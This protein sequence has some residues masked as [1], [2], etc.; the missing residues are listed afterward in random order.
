MSEPTEAASETPKKASLEW[1][2]LSL[3]G[4]Q[5]EGLSLSG[6]RTSIGLPQLNACFDVAQALPFA[7]KYKHFFISHGHQDHA[8]GLPY[9]I[10]QKNMNSHEPAQI[11]LP[12]ELAGPM[13]EI[14]SLWQ[15][16]E[17]HQYAY[18]LHPLSPDEEVLLNKAH[19]VKAFPTVHRIPSLG[20]TLFEKKKKLK[21]EWAHLEPAA[22]G[23]KKAEGFEIEDIHRTPAFSF[24]G[25][26]QIEFLYS[27]D[28]IRKSRILCLETT[29]ID[30]VKSVEHAR[31]WGHTHLFE[32]VP[33]LKN[34]ESEKIVL[35]HLSSRYGH[36][37]S[38][39]LIERVRKAIPTEYWERVV[40]FTGR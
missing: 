37:H 25:D 29:Y 15:K 28:W 5:L 30:E 13:A 7:V 10:S 4:L 12:R 8:G 31:R 16:I 33:E 21:R 24:T 36:S 20:Y 11:Y 35:I 34:I 22:I 2:N 3:C 23:Q 27:R 39:A 19:F 26:T 40:V 18:H 1:A 32:L 9:L 6:I 38:K 14:L 17:D